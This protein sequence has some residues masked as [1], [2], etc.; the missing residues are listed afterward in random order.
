[1]IT[2]NDFVLHYENTQTRGCDAGI[3]HGDQTKE[4]CK[5]CKYFPCRFFLKEQ[6]DE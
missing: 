3:L 5:N 1:M 6:N 2:I 4:M